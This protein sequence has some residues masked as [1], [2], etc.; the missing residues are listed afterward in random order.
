MKI[1]YKGGTVM[2]LGLTTPALLFPAISLLMLAYTNRFIVLAG[3]MRDLYG[4]YQKEP[5]DII[6]TQLLNLRVRISIIKNM[7]IFGA[8]SFFFCV[9][10][11]FLIFAGS[12]MLANFTFGISLILLLLSLALMIRELHLSIDALEAHIS[13]FPH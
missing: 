6:A 13:E 7:Q 2:E 12:I 11:M 1:L 4:E 10:C 5:D 3:L 8:L 9:A